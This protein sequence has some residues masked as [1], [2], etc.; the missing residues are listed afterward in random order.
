MKTIDELVDSLSPEEQIRFEDAIAET[1]QRER[2]I[3]KIKMNSQQ[4]LAK[5]R[6]TIQL[7]M[8]SLIQVSSKLELL[9]QELG[10][11]CA[12]MK[13]AV[14]KSA[15]FKDQIYGLQLALI[16]EDKLFR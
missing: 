11:L 3:Q 8:E 5:Y 12:T 4:A 10:R 7:G 15:E 6:E 2:E 14:R 16:P 1:R 13:L 9:Q